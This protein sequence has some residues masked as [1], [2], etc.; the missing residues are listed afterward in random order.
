MELDKPIVEGP[1]TDTS[2]EKFKRLLNDYEPYSIVYNISPN[3]ENASDFTDLL[4]ES[5]INM[6]KRN[7]CVDKHP[8]MKVCMETLV[9]MCAHVSSEPGLGAMAV[10][11]DDTQKP[12][13]ANVFFGPDINSVKAKI[14]LHAMLSAFGI[15]NI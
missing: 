8:K 7:G 6:C 4:N 10:A 5:L 2:D 1:F 12:N 11:Y 3:D 14:E 13:V 9:S 15:E